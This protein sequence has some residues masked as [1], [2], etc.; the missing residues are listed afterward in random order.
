MS[1]NLSYQEALIFC[2]AAQ[3]KKDVAG[4]RTMSE[5]DSFI[6]NPSFDAKVY[7]QGNDIVIAFSGTDLQDKKGDGINDIEILKNKIPEQYQ[8][9]KDLY[10]KIKYNYPN[11]N[12]KMT[13]YSLGATLSNMVSCETGSPSTVIA[14]IG[15]KEATL[16]NQYYFQYGD[17]NIVSYGRLGDL[18]FSTQLNDQLGTVKLLPNV[19][20]ANLLE[21]HYL[22]N[23]TPAEAELA[24]EWQKKPTLQESVYSMQSAW[25]EKVSNPIQ[26]N[27]QQFTNKLV[28]IQNQTSIMNNIPSKV[29]YNLEYE[30]NKESILNQVA[31]MP[32]DEL[33]SRETEIMSYL[34]PQISAEYKNQQY[35]QYVNFVNNKKRI[36]TLEDIDNM[37][38][39]EFNDNFEEIK[40]QMQTIGIPSEAELKPQIQTFKKQKKYV[41]SSNKDGRWITVDGNHVFIEK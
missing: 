1:K 4:W 25:Q 32:L 9:A 26:Q 7:Q 14:P 29:P 36:I 18:L 38:Y 17:R 21:Q 16:N 10:S 15:G 5:Y 19:K 31:T 23:F 33:K 11:A 12:I 24:V 35:E 27:I 6:Q 2:D 22:H 41:D 39:E 37:A 40:F 8:N 28:P 3:N 20:T 34:R 13:G 30:R